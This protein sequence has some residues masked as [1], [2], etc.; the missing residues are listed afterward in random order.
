[1]AFDLRKRFPCRTGKGLSMLRDVRLR[2]V[3]VGFPFRYSGVAGQRRRRRLA[4][5][6]LI[7]STSQAAT[8]V[9]SPLS[10]INSPSSKAR[11][12]ASSGLAASIS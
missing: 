1:M 8:L 7:S 11:S 6:V 4:A 2:F 12:S 5:V 10:S 3:M 9:V